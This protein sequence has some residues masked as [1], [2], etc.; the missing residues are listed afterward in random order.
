LFRLYFGVI[1]KTD[2]AFL[3][4]KADIEIVLSQTIGLVDQEGVA[5]VGGFIRSLR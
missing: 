1:I 2:I 3:R 4:G 5:A